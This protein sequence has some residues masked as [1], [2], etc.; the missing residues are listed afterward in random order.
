MNEIAAA[1]SAGLVFA[2]WRRVLALAM[3]CMAPL[4]V[5]VHFIWVSKHPG[6]LT[7]VDLAAIYL[8]VAAST[9]STLYLLLSM[10]TAINRLVRM[11]DQVRRAPE[12]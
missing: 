9:V 3:V 10:Q 7:R 1:G 12:K 2:G 4:M 6:A 8:V 11:S 5:V